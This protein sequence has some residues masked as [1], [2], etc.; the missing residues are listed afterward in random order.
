MGIDDWPNEPICGIPGA[1][2]VIG[3]DI[4]PVNDFDKVHDVEILHVPIA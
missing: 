2:E 3:H 4:K 1:M